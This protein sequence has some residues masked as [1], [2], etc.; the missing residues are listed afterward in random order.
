MTGSFVARG[1]GYNG[2]MPGIRGS[3]EEFPSPT[4]Y[5]PIKFWKNDQVE[6]NTFQTG[7]MPCPILR[8]AEVLLTNAEA[9]AELGTAT[10]GILDM[11]INKLRDRVGM[12]HLQVSNLP[13]DPELDAEYAN[14][15]GYVPNPLLREIRRERRVELAFENFRWDDLIRWKAGGMLSRDE[16]IRGMK[17]N[18]YEYPNVV[19]GSDVYLDTEG[20]LAPYTN[21]LPSGR[22]FIE[23]KQYYFPIPLE[24]LVM[25][26]NLTQSPGW[27]GL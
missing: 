15:C 5:W 23:P 11:T 16:A 8:Y 26:P 6:V 21:S 20:Y 3:G 17:F 10:Q 25:N 9:H 1:R 22:T 12:P 14:Y 4:G 13:L 24:E 18:Q 19:V 27:D 7:I 2:L